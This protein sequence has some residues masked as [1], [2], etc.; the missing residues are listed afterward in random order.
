MKQRGFTLFEVI[1]VLVITGLISVVLIQ[2]LGIVLAAR[3]SFSTKIV[4]VDR[5]VLKQNLILSPLRGVVPDYNDRPN[6]FKG[7]AREMRGLTV[8]T[9][10][11]RVGTPTGFTLRLEYVSDR[12][13]TVVIYKEEGRPPLEIAQWKG[14]SGTFS[15]RD[16]TG[17]WRDKWPINDK[18]SQTP[19][20]IRLASGSEEVPTVAANVA[21]PH[22]RTL[23][24]QDSPLGNGMKQD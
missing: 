16:R 6:T 1:V 22:R 15:Y 21:G 19:W 18:V 9:L 11:E 20:V 10:Q 14:N 7:G 13:E 12:A 2:G 4:A 8:G 24:I 17:D 5:I 23:R 3:S